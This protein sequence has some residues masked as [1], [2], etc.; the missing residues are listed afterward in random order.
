[1]KEAL[2]AVSRHESS[3]VIVGSL[4]ADEKAD[5]KAAKV[6]ERDLYVLRFKRTLRQLALLQDFADAMVAVND[7]RG[8]ASVS[9][10][11]RRVSVMQS[12]GMTV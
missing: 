11:A 5:E 3:A 2:V 10:I 4:Q 7:I 8:A 9:G 12:V 1:M 6:L